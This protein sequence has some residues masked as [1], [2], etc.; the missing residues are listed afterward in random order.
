MR[1]ITLT[2]DEKN[3]QNEILI[4]KGFKHYAAKCGMIQ[5]DLD[6]QLYINKKQGSKLFQLEIWRNKYRPLIKK[7]DEGGV[8]VLYNRLKNQL[9]QLKKE[10]DRI[11]ELDY[12]KTIRGLEGVI[13]HRNNIIDTLRSNNKKVI[14]KKEIKRLRLFVEKSKHVLNKDEFLDTW[15]EV[16]KEI[17][18]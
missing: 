18:Q 15:K 10:K 7:L 3:F 11:K 17:N 9:D 8:Q 12:G 1:D 14:E 5:S 6:E 13:K 4:V 2:P 16:D